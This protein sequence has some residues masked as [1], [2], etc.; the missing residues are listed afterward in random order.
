MGYP[1]YGSPYADKHN[2][3]TSTSGTVF[4][5][6]IAG[7]DV[8]SVGSVCVKKHEEPKMRGLSDIDEQSE[9]I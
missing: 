4:Q 8:G 7:C 1:I 5:P 3:D 2:M 6:K 9:M